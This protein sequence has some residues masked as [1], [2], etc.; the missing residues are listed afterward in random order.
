MLADFMLVQSQNS[1]AAFSPMTFLGFAVISVRSNHIGNT[2]KGRVPMGIVGG[3]Q[4][5]VGAD[6][7]DHFAET[8]FHRLRRSKALPA[9]I[10]ARFHLEP[11]HLKRQNS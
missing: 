11:R 10:V 3:E 5:T 8:A 6:R 1:R 4:H 7:V 2:G 9:K